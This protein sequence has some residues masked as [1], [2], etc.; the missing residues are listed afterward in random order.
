[1]TKYWNRK[2]KWT[3]QKEKIDKIL[4]NVGFKEDNIIF[5]SLNNEEVYSTLQLF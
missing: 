1:M 2:L 5:N 3:K 4:V